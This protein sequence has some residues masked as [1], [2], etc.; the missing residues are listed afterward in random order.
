[1]AIAV[2]SIC[3]GGVA[4]GGVAFAAGSGSSAGTQLVSMGPLAPATPTH[5]LVV[6]RLLMPSKKSH[7]RATR[8]RRPADFT[9]QKEKARFRPASASLLQLGGSP[10]AAPNAP[11][12]ATDAMPGS[13]P[14]AGVGFTGLSE[15]SVP[16][17]DVQIAAGT[18]HLAEMVNVELGVWSKR[19]AEIGSPVPLSTLFGTGQDHIGDP[20]L[21]FD[22]ATGRWFSSIVDITNGSV[23]LG[24][25][26][27]SDVSGTWWFY[28]FPIS[29]CPDQPRL[30]VDG[31]QVLISVNLLTVCSEGANNSGA[32]VLV[33]AK[34]NL[35]AG[36][37]AN[38]QL[39]AS[40][41][42]FAIAPA[43]VLGSG[44]TG[45]MASLDA[46]YT[47]T[48]HV[49]EV[50]GLPP[51]A[52]VTQQDLPLAPVVQDPPAA[53]QPG[54]PQIDTGDQRLE[55][56]VW[57]NGELFVS[58]ND[59]CTSLEQQLASCAGVAAVSTN[60]TPSLLW[61][62][63]FA[64]QG[65]DAFYPAIR[66]DPDGNLL[67]CFGTSSASQYPSGAVA[68][69]KN[70]GTP[71]STY[72][73][74]QSGSSPIQNN[75]YGDYFGA[76]V[77]PTNPQTIWAAAEVGNNRTGVWGSAV[78]AVSATQVPVTSPSPDRSSKPRR[79]RKRR[80]R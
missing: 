55:D 49:F 72:A 53:A 80:R 18:S 56:A 67:V 4:G 7:R 15:Q 12:P 21:L 10:D 66:P 73:V 70:D 40:S 16:P 37:P 38:V 75:R 19:G 69:V 2:V 79:G 60:G 24:V 41:G 17:P 3:I 11:A 25:S 76:A 36:Q 32:R 43:Q 51:Q 68:V 46:H 20:R 8:N 34:S 74:V 23:Y 42:L 39:F 44:S 26:G 65:G 52:T 57:Q 9:A 48:L 71:S 30:G 22:A 61:R 13:L 47:N 5:R 78:R 64:T 1:M 14:A 58:F 59:A 28:R 77:D 35:L 45:W 29:G 31:S 33:I 54:G 62:R 6:R 63:D 50:S 27:S